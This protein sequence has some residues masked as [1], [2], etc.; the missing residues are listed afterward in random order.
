MFH[1]IVVPIKSSADIAADSLLD[2]DPSIPKMTFAVLM[3][4]Y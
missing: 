4:L 1:V 3:E 2:M